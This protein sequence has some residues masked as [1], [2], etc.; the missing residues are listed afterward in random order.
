MHLLLHMAWLEG[1]L[2]R[3]GCP[4]CTLRLGHEHDWLDIFTYDH[5]GDPGTNHMLSESLGFCHRHAWAIAASERGPL[6]LALTYEP[7]VRRLLG[8]GAHR[9]Q[10][11]PRVRQRRREPWAFAPGRRCPACQAMAETDEIYARVFA[12]S[13][14]SGEFLALYARSEGLC[15]AHRERV[16]AAAEATTRTDLLRAHVARLEAANRALAPAGQGGFLPERV[17]PWGLSLLVGSDSNVRG[18]S[19]GMPT[20]HGGG[21]AICALERDADVEA[22]AGIARDPEMLPAGSWL[23][24]RHARQAQHLAQPGGGSGAFRAWLRAALEAA[25]AACLT[26]LERCAEPDGGRAQGRR[27]RHGDDP[28]LGARKCPVCTLVGDTVRRRIA[29]P[30]AVPPGKVCLRHLATYPPSTVDA[31]MRHAQAVAARLQ[32]LAVDLDQFIWKSSWERRHEPKGR[33]Q[34]SW[35]RAISLFVGDA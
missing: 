11:R 15:L 24:A 16:L 6:A 27:S 22:Q 28:W 3:A 20:S 35:R 25:I 18:M 17:V 23:C 34:D 32:E 1:A 2:E 26:G 10:P 8:Q 21:C 12:R 31:G 5:S 33:E 14:G 19:G 13:L 4:I 29:A 9:G 30:D 7:L